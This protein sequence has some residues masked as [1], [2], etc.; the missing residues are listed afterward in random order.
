MN[1]FHDQPYTTGNQSIWVELMN[2][3]TADWGLSPLPAKLVSLR[4][5]LTDAPPGSVPADAIVIENAG[6]TL[7]GD[8][9][10]E[11]VVFGITAAIAI[12]CFA[13]FL[14]YSYYMGSLGLSSQAELPGDDM[15]ERRPLGPGALEQ[16]GGTPDSPGADG[17]MT[18]EAFQ[19]SLRNYYYPPTVTETELRERDYVAEP[20]DG[21]DV[22][23]AT[24]LL[25]RMYANDLEIWSHGSDRSFNADARKAR[26][27][28]MLREVRGRFE[29]WGAAANGSG[30][31]DWR[32]EVQPLGLREGW[33]AAPDL[34][35][36]MQC[37]D[38]EQAQGVLYG[39]STARAGWTPEEEH[40]L[41]KAG[42]FLFSSQG[43]HERR[44]P[45][46]MG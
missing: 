41:L 39:I 46:V 3:S 24:E 21:D 5:S 43:I 32:A 13:G 12:A 20:A 31:I 2:K 7:A 27:D 40:E 14:I 34:A 28:A 26:S 45:E 8:K 35:R 6:R 16:G 29:A 25:R 19:R 18:D 15:N 37:L 17:F 11:V 1:S 33:Q 42:L 30:R 9:P 4:G 23:A 22:E 10:I 36:L 44:Y 38:R